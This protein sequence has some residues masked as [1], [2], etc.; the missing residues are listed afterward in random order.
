MAGRAIGGAAKAVGGAGLGCLGRVFGIVALIGLFLVGW[1]IWSLVGHV[2]YLVDG[3]SADAAAF[4]ARSSV[5]LTGEEG[6]GGL[7]QI[8]GPPSHAGKVANITN[9]K[10]YCWYTDCRI[11]AEVI[12]GGTLVSL[13][14]LNGGFYGDPVF[15]GTFNSLKIGGAAPGPGE[16][17]G[18]NPGFQWW[19]KNGRITQMSYSVGTYEQ[20]AH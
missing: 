12:D 19:A 15:Q 17:G 20:P 1:A 8:F 11:K 10:D 13:D 2:Y 14:V 18:D 16:R 5:A 4:A 9:A 7:E 6:L 3:R